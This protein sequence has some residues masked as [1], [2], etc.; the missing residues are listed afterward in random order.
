MGGQQ[1]NP[2]HVQMIP[3]VVADIRSRPSVLSNI[4]D[5]QNHSSGLSRAPM[6]FRF[7]PFQLD[8]ILNQSTIPSDSSSQR[9]VQ[10]RNSQTEQGTPE[11][12]DYVVKRHGKQLLLGESSSLAKRSKRNSAASS[13]TEVNRSTFESQEKE[14]DMLS[15]L[16]SPSN[17]REMKNSLYDPAFEAIG[18]PI[19]PHLRMFQASKQFLQ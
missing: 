13:S 4:A 15:N 7:A 10:F 17:A 12:Q 1:K 5:P 14:M 2:D 18:L 6:P 19:D 3:D 16:F 11:Q 8:D 9:S